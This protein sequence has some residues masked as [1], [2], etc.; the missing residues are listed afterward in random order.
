M[1]FKD[2]FLVV[3]S[4]DNPFRWKGDFKTSDAIADWDDDGEEYSRDILNPVQII[5]F[6]T[7]DGI[8]YIWYAKQNRYND[9]YWEIAFGVVKKEKD[10]GGFETDITKTGTGNSFRVFAT[11]I[12]ITNYFIEFD[13]NNEIHYLTFTSKGN[14]R[15]KLYKK[16]LVPRIDKFEISY[17][18]SS[19]EDETEIH[20]QR[21]S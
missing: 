19:G 5:H 6:Q 1:Q 20:L 2:V 11:V 10:D 21:I 16:Y 3:E 7:D 9:N 8:P 15:T 4:L 12:D 18:G 14:N 13:E 17:E